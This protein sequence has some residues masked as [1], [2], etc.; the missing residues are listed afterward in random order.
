MWKLWLLEHIVFNKF[1]YKVDKVN[2]I[3]R[4]EEPNALFI[5]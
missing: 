3:S 4:D 1:A 5:V 2:Y